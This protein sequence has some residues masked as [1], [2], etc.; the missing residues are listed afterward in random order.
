MSVPLTTVFRDAPEPLFDFTVITVCRN[1]LSA[2]KKTVASVIGQKAVSADLR[3]E[4]VIVDG[5]STDGTPEWL[6]DMLAKGNIEAYISEPDGGIYDA[7]N[8]GINMARGHVLLFLNA[9]DT[10]AYADLAECVLPVV[11]G[12]CGA[13]AAVTHWYASGTNHLI[14]PKPHR[15]YLASPMCHQ[16][17][18]VSAALTRQLG[19]YDS[20]VFR[21]AGD[22][23]FM[24]RIVQ[25][26]GFPRIV[27]TT[28]SY[29]PGGGFSTNCFFTYGD[30]LIEILYRN[31]Q[32]MFDLCRTDADFCRA[33]VV[34]LFS[35]CVT[36][37][38]WKTTY[39]RDIRPQLI[40]LQELCRQVEPLVPDSRLRKAARFLAGTYLADMIEHNANSSSRNWRRLKWHSYAC[41]LASANLYRGAAVEPRITCWA[42]GKS[43]C[44]TALAKLKKHFGKA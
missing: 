11:R 34:T 42:R 22:T 7:M 30:E 8:K 13:V 32:Q 40:K 12:E 20:A 29:M 6:A 28:V 2:L 27:E 33:L 25:K 43:L 4:H 41:T 5:A 14:T 10:L 39:T 19:G 9:D 44:K 15:L 35:H 36:M 18:F 17:L 21:C 23:D 16:A 31:Q 3:I 26:N 1:V 37:R 24:H 38:H